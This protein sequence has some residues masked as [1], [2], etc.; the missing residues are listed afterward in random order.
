VNGPTVSVVLLCYD[1]VETLRRALASIA[2][3]TYRALEVLVVSNLS[4]RTGEIASLVAEYPRFR[5]I[6]IS[7]NAGFTGGM[8]RGIAEASGTYIYLTQDDIELEAECI[9]VLVAACD[10]D[11]SIGLACPLMVDAASA[12]IRSAGG[13][14]RLEPIYRQADYA[15]GELPETFT[16]M[17]DVTYIPGN[18]MFARASLLRGLGAF[19]DDFFMYYDDVDLCARALRAGERIVVQPAARVLNL[20][21]PSNQSGSAFAEYHKIKNLYLVYLL[22]GSAV[23]LPEFFLR[24]GVVMWLRSPRSD[25]GRLRMRAM[26][27]VAGSLLRILG[28]RRR[29]GGASPAD[30]RRRLREAA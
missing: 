26:R 28:E 18:M 29:M 11:P 14:F 19:R 10:R 9:Q 8:N 17:R 24:Y 22:H 21:P 23:V 5:L 3:Q 12:R 25:A 16:A 15:A 20:D 27:W 2:S 7:F 4:A 1:R 13:W 30:F 6:E